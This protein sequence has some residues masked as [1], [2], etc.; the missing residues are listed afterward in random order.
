MRVFFFFQMT[1]SLPNLQY[2]SLLIPTNLSLFHINKLGLL[3]AV[4]AV[5]HTTSMFTSCDAAC[6]LP[7]VL[8][9]YYPSYHYPSY[10]YPSYHY[11]SY[12]YPSY[13]YPSYHFHADLPTSSDTVRIYL[14]YIGSFLMCII[15]KK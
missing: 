12:H 10:H 4:A 6:L 8:I 1:Q 14:Y 13:H 11:P 9:N 5:S 3:T 15:H 7:Q 2:Y